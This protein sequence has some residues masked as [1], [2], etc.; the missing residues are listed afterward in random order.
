MVSS[1]I[2]VVAFDV[3]ETLVDL[4]GLEGAFA[5]VRLDPALIPLWFARVLRDGFALTAAGGFRPFAEVATDALAGLAPGQV[6]GSAASVVLAAFRELDVHPDVEP[7]LRRL[8]SAGVRAVTLTNGSAEVTQALLRRAGLAS[9][10]EQTLSVDAVERWKPAPEPY[11]YAAS[12]CGVPVSRMALVAAHSWDCDGARRAGL[13]TGW[14][15]RLE[16]TRPSIFLEPD[17]SGPDLTSV[18]AALLGLRTEPS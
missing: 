13:R 2:D 1:A 14:V 3:N 16:V 11:L 5:E 12:A 6:D 4:R 18:V 10:V 8:A 9:L 17:V 15:S 7:A